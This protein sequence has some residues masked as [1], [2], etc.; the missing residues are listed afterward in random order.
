MLHFRE[1]EVGARAAFDEFVGIVEEEESEIEKRARDW[2]IV[3]GDTG[4]VEV[5]SAGA[6]RGM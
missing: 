4:F 6:A 2:T 1:V 3:D 5:P